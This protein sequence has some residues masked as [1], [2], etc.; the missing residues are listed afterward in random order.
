MTN[1]YNT[2]IINNVRYIKYLHKKG[3]IKMRNIFAQNTTINTNNIF[4]DSVISG[5]DC[6]EENCVNG[7]LL[8]NIDY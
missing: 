5:F 1:G 6:G 2:I 8:L 7:V 4:C 3:K